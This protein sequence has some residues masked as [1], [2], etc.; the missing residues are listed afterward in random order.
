[1][2]HKVS[3]VLYTYNDAEHI[4]P[5]VHDL[6][7]H[8]T[9][10]VELVIV[11]DAST[12]STPAVVGSLSLSEKYRGLI[13]VISHMEHVG[14][15]RSYEDGVKASRAEYVYCIQSMDSLH[16]EELEHLVKSAEKAS[17]DMAVP[18]LT[19]S[20]DP[21]QPKEHVGKVIIPPK[22]SIA[23]PDIVN[24]L[25]IGDAFEPQV[26]GWLF[27]REL[28]LHSFAEVLPEELAK[29]NESGIVFIASMR[30]RL[31]LLKPDLY[32]LT[33]TTIF[34]IHL[35]S[36]EVFEDLCAE[37]KTLQ[38]C[39]QYLMDEKLTE[40]YQD[41]FVGLSLMLCTRVCRLFPA[42]VPS[43]FWKEGAELL[44]SS[45]GASAVATSY[46]HLPQASL[47]EVAIALSS[48][49]PNGGGKRIDR[50]LLLVQ[51]QEQLLD[52]I[53]YADK[54]TRAKK[55]VSFIIEENVQVST[56][57]HIACKLPSQ[58]FNETRA[59]ELTR[60]IERQHGEALIVF[61][62]ERRFAYDMLLARSLGLAVGLVCEKGVFDPRRF[63][64]LLPQVA[65]AQAVV[66]DNTI[67]CELWSLLGT[68]STTLYNLTTKLGQT[69]RG[70]TR[71]ASLELVF[72][73]SRLAYGYLQ[74]R[75][76]LSDYKTHE[77]ER[78]E[79]KARELDILEEQNEQL[80]KE[81]FEKE[82]ELKEYKGYF[83][84]RLSRRIV[85]KRLQQN[86]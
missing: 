18:S 81:L 76:I 31:L 27:S 83:E 13:R 32:P 73:L 15:L 17:A 50:V 54:L 48:G 59:K 55:S 3:V 1:M 85:L 84:G 24:S 5:A 60:A 26:T 10:D 62:R 41:A 64:E 57:L 11:D 61:A 22:G 28:L 8:A 47:S 30:A 65:F 21:Q 33:T 51:S 45:W 63:L 20:E 43:E 75:A 71:L 25:F 86:N 68:D 46:A 2:K 58:V 78:Q 80:K 42:R 23:E 69:K 6:L 67:E 16:V 79:K 7:H 44:L 53:A 56:G 12:D 40:T 66:C 19:F 37:H 70:R 72:S 38:I 36:T 4:E 34:S 14:K 9:F 35:R 29:M 52:A 39:E 82:R 74:S 77:K 49:L